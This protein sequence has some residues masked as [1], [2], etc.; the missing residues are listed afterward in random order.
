MT[1]SCNKP[2]SSNEETAVRCL[3]RKGIPILE[4]IPAEIKKLEDGYYAYMHAPTSEFFSNPIPADYEVEITSRAFRKNMKCLH[5]VE[6]IIANDQSPRCN[7]HFDFVLFEVKN[8]KRRNERYLE[9]NGYQHEDDQ[10]FGP[11]STAECLI[12]DAIKEAWGAKF[13]KQ[14]TKFWDE[15]LTYLDKY[16]K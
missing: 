11:V 9:V 15:F 13:F 8:G 4:Y 12:S 7:M 6:E 3:N 16:K 2:Q 10:S 14:S 5:I 1:L